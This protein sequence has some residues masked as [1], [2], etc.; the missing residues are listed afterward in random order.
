VG[1]ELGR[2]L[3]WEPGSAE[4]RLVARRA[5]EQHRDGFLVKLRARVAAGPKVDRLRAIVLARS[6]GVQGEIELELLAVAASAGDDWLTATAVGALGDIQTSS[7]AEVVRRFI[8]HDCGRVRSNA[9]EA[10]LR[11]TDAVEP[12]APLD[13]RLVELK[14]DPHHR[15]RASVLRALLAGPHPLDA[16]AL[17]DLA[18]MLSD[19][20]P[21][22]RLAALWAVERLALAPAPGS[23]SPMVQRI[24]EFSTLVAQAARDDPEEP[25]RER[26]TR[27][28]ARMLA[29]VRL[30]WRSGAAVPGREAA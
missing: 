21:L 4:S 9:A 19:P 12:G 5:L 3:R 28:A 20:R 22:H 16:G 13:G 26:A 7:A 8:S 30:M 23:G 15:A 11:R 24:G 2:T 6:L 25:V 27:C 17:P 29:R 1:E 10:V 14:S 18:A